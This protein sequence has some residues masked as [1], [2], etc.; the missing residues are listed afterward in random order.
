M[1]K[2]RVVCLAGSV[3]LGGAMA[4]FPAENP[5]ITQVENGL[6]PPVLLEDDKTWSLEERMKH[7]GVNG[8]SIAVIHDSKIE[9]AKG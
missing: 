9:W 3:L 6:R 8:V 7:F 1:L 4:A 5:R 2:D